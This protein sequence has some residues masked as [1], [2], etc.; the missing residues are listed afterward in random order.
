MTKRIKSTSVGLL[1]IWNTRNS[2][3]LN[4]M[5]TLGWNVCYAHITIQQHKTRYQLYVLT[6]YDETYLSLFEEEKSS[7]ENGGNA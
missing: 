3:I 6:H 5:I 4:S 1:K 2:Q 7:R